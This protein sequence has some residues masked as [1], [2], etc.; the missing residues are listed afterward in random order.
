M[1]MHLFDFSCTVHNFLI[2]WGSSKTTTTKKTIGTNV[3]HDGATT[4]QKISVISAYQGLSV[5]FGRNWRPPLP[6]HPKKNPLVRPDDH[7]PSQVPLPRIELDHC[8]VRPDTKPLSQWGTKVIKNSSVVL[9][10]C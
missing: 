1:G 2:Y 10:H 4:Y 6:P 9:L 7:K 3:E 8:D 5:V